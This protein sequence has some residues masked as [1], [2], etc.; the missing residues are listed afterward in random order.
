MN[1]DRENNHGEYWADEGIYIRFNMKKVWAWLV[2]LFLLSGVCQAQF[3]YC[4]VDVASQ[5][6]P[7]GGVAKQ[8]L[9][10]VLIRSQ[11]LDVV[12]GYTA[13]DITVAAN[14]TT[15]P[16]GTLTAER[17][18]ASA[19]T[20]VKRLSSTSGTNRPLSAG[21]GTNYRSSIYAKAG[22]HNF[23][24]IGDNG[25]DVSRAVTVNLSNCTIGLNTNNVASSIRSVG[26]GW[27]EINTVGI[28][29]DVCGGCKN[30]S[31]DVYMVAT[32]T[33]APNTTLVGTGTETVFSWGAQQNV[34]TTAPS[35]YLA[36][37]TVGLT[38]GPLCP[39]GYMQSLTDPSRCF[40]VGPVTSRTI[41][42]W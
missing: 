20:S 37:T 33:S 34:A 28:R 36:T 30:L 3:A 17:L 7:T 11:E 1:T 19:G 2:S 35:D 23:I 16:D 31:L 24:S 25:D 27:C 5:L 39:L 10:N 22:T 40:I 41:R 38:L 6:V 14:N 4:G 26:N 18:T 15:A 8:T 29:T 42:T 12:A 32:E 21:P 13:T 9:S